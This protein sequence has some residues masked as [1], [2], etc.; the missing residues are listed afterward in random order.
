MSPA[1]V[2]RVLVINKPKVVW[3]DNC[4]WQ[5]SLIQKRLS[6]GA[7]FCA[8]MTRLL[9]IS[10]VFH[11]FIFILLCFYQNM[12]SCA[13]A[14]QKLLNP[15]EV[16]VNEVALHHCTECNQMVVL[17]RK[18]SVVEWSPADLLHWTLPELYQNVSKLSLSCD[19][20]HNLKLI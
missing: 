15:L 2:A 5:L 14:F 3:I 4:L 8:S 11:S 1:S 6:P 9:I 16:R 13:M 7:N 17:Q 20:L 19:W 12:P 18:I 10:W